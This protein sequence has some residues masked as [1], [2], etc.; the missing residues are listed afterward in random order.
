MKEGFDNAWNSS[1]MQ[2]FRQEQLNG[3][4]GNLC[5]RECDMKVTC[6]ENDQ[7]RK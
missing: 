7:L 6:K 3:N 1:K 2:K 5:Q 4:Y